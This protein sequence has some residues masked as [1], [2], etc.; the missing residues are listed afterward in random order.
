VGSRSLEGEITPR[1]TMMLASQS[2]HRIVTQIRELGHIITKLVRK[3][4]EI[5]Q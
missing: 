3:Y 1:V 2:P 5:D 4:Y